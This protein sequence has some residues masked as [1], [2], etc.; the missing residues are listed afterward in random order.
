[1]ADNNDK[2]KAAMDEVDRNFEAVRPTLV[3]SNR[4][5]TEPVTLIAWLRQ[6]QQRQ[7]EINR[8]LDR[9]MSFLGAVD[10]A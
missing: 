10:R 1:M 7:E 4:P 2:I 8:K 3:P 6:T 5:G 9:I